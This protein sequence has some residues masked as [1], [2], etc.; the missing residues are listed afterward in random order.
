MII[1]V[2]KTIFTIVVI[3]IFTVVVITIFTIEKINY[4]TLDNETRD[5]LP[6]MFEVHLNQEKVNESPQ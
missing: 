4:K 3:T 1:N 2:I 6:I 5:H